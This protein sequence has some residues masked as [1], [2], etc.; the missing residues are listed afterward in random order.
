MA[1][2]RAGLGHVEAIDLG[3]PVPGPNDVLVRVLA[4]GVCRT[5][6]HVVDGEL[7]DPAIPVVPGHEIVGRVEEVGRDVTAHAVGDR[8]GIPWLG[9]TCGVCT[10]CRTGHENLCPRGRYTGYQL[11]GGYADHAVADSSFCF[12]IPDRYDDQHAAPLLCAGLIGYRAYRMAGPGARMGVYGFGAAAHIIAQV[13]AHQGREVYAFVAPGDDEAVRFAREV[14]A[15]WAGYSNEPPPCDLDSAIIFAPVGALV[16]EA[17]SRVVPG[18]V[19]VCAGIH[20]SDIPAFPYRLLWKERVLRSVANLTRRDAREFLAIVAVVPVRTHVRAYA[21]ADANQAL[22][23]LRRG[24]FSGAAVL[25][26]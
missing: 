2:T 3:K 13:A 4:C 7:P 10:F 25:V 14:G 12:P 20:M 15:T 16:P 6:L 21:L 24:R 11:N 9:W 23:D 18:G 17:L 22:E 8:I 5:D 1:L 19:V 26:P